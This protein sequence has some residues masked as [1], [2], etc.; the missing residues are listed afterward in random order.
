MSVWTFL[1]S[2]PLPS[3]VVVSGMV[4]VGVEEEEGVGEDGVGAEGVDVG[5]WVVVSGGWVI[6]TA[7]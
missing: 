2:S 5:V 4:D 3:V 7:I 6:L 1:G